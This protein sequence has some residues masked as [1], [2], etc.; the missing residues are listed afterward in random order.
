MQMPMVL[1]T[2]FHN[3]LARVL[4]THQN[5]SVKATTK[6]VNMSSVGVESEEE[7]SISK[8]QL[9]CEMKISAQ[10]SR[11]KDLCSKLDSAIAENSQMGEFFNPNN[12]QMAFPNVL[13]AAQSSGGH[14][15][16]YQNSYSSNSIQGKP[17]LGKPWEPQLSAGKDGT[18][19]PE[20]S[21]RYCKDMGHKLENCLQLHNQ[22]EFLAPK[23]SKEG[24]N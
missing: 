20:K 5:W 21:C 13:H 8:S 17:F 9:K 4:G 23:E 15:Y 10:S 1:F 6:S 2:Q 7:G 11:I 22:I 18:A 24:L 3:E 19:D 12:L 14:G 16:S